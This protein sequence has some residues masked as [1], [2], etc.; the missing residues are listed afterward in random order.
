MTAKADLAASVA[1][2]LLNLAKESGVDYQT[3]LTN[4]C[5]E[6][7]LYRLGASRLR[8]RFVLK[9]AMVL[10]LWSDRP[11]RATRD[12][13]LLRKGDAGEE[14]ILADLKDVIATPAPPDSVRFSGDRLRLES[15][16]AEDEYAGT[17]AILPALCG[18]ARVV[19][20]IDMGVGDAVWPPP[21]ESV[22][23]ALLG[24]PSPELLA[25]PREAVIAEKLE[26][27]LVLGD[28]NSR[29]K[30]FFDLHHLARSFEFDREVLA[31]AIQR[32]LAWR[33]TPVPAGRPIG[34]T[35]AFW[36]NPSR[37]AQVRA[38]ARRAGLEVPADPEEEIAP[39]LQAFFLPVLEDLATGVPRRGTWVPGGPWISAQDGVGPSA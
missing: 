3:V 29:I 9:G 33:G 26:A 4:F 2:R 21:Q 39:I 14:A 15:I 19:L 27:M 38:F 25:Y 10:R 8:K 6:R 30:D 16:R 11:Y 18:R 28:R 31:E 1:A 35:S 7:F 17:R 24:F 13:D 5:L 34:L 32:T 36:Q 12:L 22:Y 23:P 20:K 37:P